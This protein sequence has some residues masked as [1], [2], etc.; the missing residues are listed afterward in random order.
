MLSPYINVLRSPAI[1]PRFSMTIQ[2]INEN[3]QF[4]APDQYFAAEKLISNGL[5]YHLVSVFGSQSTG[6]STLLNALFGTSFSVMDETKRSQTTKGIWLGKADLTLSLSTEASTEASAETSETEENDNSSTSENSDGFVSLTPMSQPVILVLDVEGTDGRERGE[7]QDFERKAALFAL[8]TSECLIVNMWENQVGLY[9][10]ANMGLLKTVFEV[11]LSLFSG[12]KQRSLILFVIRDHLGTTPLENLSETLLKDLQNHWKSIS[13]PPGLEMSQIFDFF[14]IQ[15]HALPHKILMKQAFDQEVALLA[16]RFDHRAEKLQEPQGPTATSVERDSHAIRSSDYIFKPDYHRNVPIDGWSMYA[17]QIWQQIEDNKDLDLPTQQILVARFRCDEIANEAWAAFETNLL[18]S[19]LRE[20]VLDTGDTAYYSYF[21][22]DVAQ[23]RINALSVFDSMA[24][25]Y[26]DSVYLSKRSDLEQRIDTELAKYLKLHLQTVQTSLM[27]KLKT[28]AV[29]TPSASF[30]QELLAAKQDC[31]FQFTV[32]AKEASLGVLPHHEETAA[33]TKELNKVEADLRDQQIKRIV[34]GAA[35]KIKTVIDE[36]LENYFK[37]PGLDLWDKVDL[38]FQNTVDRALVKYAK[39]DGSYAFNTGENDAE[40]LNTIKKDAWI[41]LDDR[42]KEICKDNNVVIMLRA[43]FETAFKYDKNNLPIVWKPSDDIEGAFID[44]RQ[45]AL[46]KLDIVAVAKTMSGELFVPDADEYDLDNEDRDFSVRISN[47]RKENISEQ[48]RRIA[49]S[50]Y[51][52]AKRSTVQTAT[53]IPFYMIVLL[54]ILGWN[55]FMAVLRSPF[56]FI[57]LL[58]AAGA[59]Y[60]THTLN[61]WGPLLQVA[62]AMVNKTL[63]VARDKLRESLQVDQNYN[64]RRK[65]F[66]LQ[67]LSDRKKEDGT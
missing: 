18:Q 66:A 25:R 31:L 56:L 33:F 34:A 10:G 36:E 50:I 53:Q 12:K 20:K 4:L 6:K 23:L 22:N 63:E 64:P 13:K 57:L 39:P 11:N 8:A 7:D 30:Q 48:F 15:F 37:K 44:A 62:N 35:K 60:V 47:S 24:S 32:E 26:A 5:N 67:D 61:M 43:N 58:L 55:E 42:L 49:D 41:A 28:F 2:L 1:S 16:K 51:V 52:D 17:D 54:I 27:D 3:K 46:K 19:H 29:S 21:G 38:F 14:D 45:T 65:E 9:Q 59:A 40:I